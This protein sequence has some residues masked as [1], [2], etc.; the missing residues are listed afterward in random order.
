[1][2][3]EKLSSI[4]YPK[5]K[6]CFRHH[7]FYIWFL[8]NVPMGGTSHEHIYNKRREHGSGQN[9]ANKNWRNTKKMV[10][11]DTVT[12]LTVQPLLSI[13]NLPKIDSVCSCA[14]MQHWIL[15]L[16]GEQ[17]IKFKRTDIIRQMWRD[18]LVYLHKANNLR[19]H[20]RCLW[21]VFY[22]REWESFH[23]NREDS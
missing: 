8:P 3:R 7:P 15:F 23:H 4:E 22:H 9:S 13:F 6:A 18:W 21:Q 1:M 2:N 16:E 11:P 12:A 19:I 14:W 5:I 20:I 17:I 10:I